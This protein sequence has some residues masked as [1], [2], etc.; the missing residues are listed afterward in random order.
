MARGGAQLL[1]HRRT[2]ARAGDE[3]QAG[4][5]PV[6]RPE[7]DERKGGTINI[8]SLLTG[9]CVG[10]VAQ[11]EPLHELQDVTTLYYNEQRNALY[12]GDRNGIL[13]VLAQ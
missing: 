1:E 7:G 4:A 12:L 6:E 8:S 5:V 13:R 9:K 3:R 10:K 2:A 11:G